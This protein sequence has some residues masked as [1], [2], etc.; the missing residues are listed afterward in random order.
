MA[1]ALG[2]NAQTVVNPSFEDGTTGWN[3]SG[4]KTQTNNSFTIKAGNT[5]MEKWTSRGNTVGDAHVYQQVRNLPLGVYTLTVAAQNIQEDTPNATQSGAWIYAGDSIATVDVR[6][7]YTLRFLCSSGSVEVGFKAVSPTGNWIS[8]DN[9]RLVEVDAVRDELGVFLTMAKSLRC[10]DMYEADRTAYLDILHQAQGIYDAGSETG[11]AEVTRTLLKA[12]EQADAAI[13]QYKR[14]HASAESPLDVT[15]L[16]TNPSFEYGWDGWSGWNIQLQ[17]NTSFTLKHGSTYVEKWTGRGGTIGNSGIQQ[18]IKNMEPGTYI[19]KAAAQNIQEDTPTQK[20]TGAWLVGNQSRTPVYGRAEYEVKFTH[21]DT[22]MKIAFICEDAKGNWVATDNFRLYYIGS[23][24]SVMAQEVADRVANAKALLEQKMNCDSREALEI[25]ISAAESFF[26]TAGEEVTATRPIS[27]LPTVADALTQASDRAKKSVSAY[28]ALEKAIAEA[29]KNYGLGT[30]LKADEYRAAIDTAISVWNDDASQNSALSAQLQALSDAAFLYKINNATGA[31]PKVVTDPRTVHG[32]KE[33]FG[34]MTVS[35]VSS[36]KIKEQGFV[37]SATN[38]EPT[39]LDQRANDYLE[40]NGRIYR[41]SMSPGTLYYI[42]AYCMTN[43]YAVGYGDV[44]RVS[45]LP[46]GHVTWSYDYG[47]DEEAQNN[48][49]ENALKDATGWWSNYTSITGFNIDGHWSPGTPTADCG[50][51]GYMRI[52]TNMGQRCGTVMHEMNHGVGTGTT[53]IWGGDSDS[54]LRVSRNGDWA[55][56]HANGNIQFWEN[57]DNVVICGAY[58]AY[59]WGI[60]HPGQAYEDGG[61]GTALWMNKYAINGAHLEPGAWA[62][63]SNWNDEQILYIGNSIITQGFMEDGM[64]PVNYWSGGV[65]LPTYTFAH[66]DDAKYYLTNEDSKRGRLK[67][68]LVEQAS[69]TLRWVTSDL[70][71]NPDL[72][73][74]GD[75]MNDRAAWYVSFDAQNQVYQFRNAVTGH[76]ISDTGTTMKAISKEKLTKNENFTLMRRRKA[77]A[78]DDPYRG[79]WI[80]NYTTRY[81]LQANASGSIGRASQNLWDTSTTQRW[82]IL[83]TEEAQ[84]MSINTDTKQAALLAEL[85]K[86]LREVEKV[87]YIEYNASADSHT[88]FVEALEAAEALLANSKADVD[89][90]SAMYTAT[91]TA[92]INYLSA[93]AAEDKPFDLTFFMTNPSV[94]TDTKGWS[95]SGTINHNCCEFYVKTFDFNQTL[96]EMPRGRF[97]ATVQGF[98]RPGSYSNAYADFLSGGTTN[99][100]F[101]LGSHSTKLAH[102]GVDAQQKRLGGG[103]A[104]VGSPTVYIPDNMEAADIYFGK[105]LYE[106]SIEHNQISK[107]KDLKL[108]IKCSSVSD[109]YWTIFRNFH[110]YF[111]GRILPTDIEEVEVAENDIPIAYYSL[112]GVRIARPDR[113]AYIIKYKDGRTLKVM[114]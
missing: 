31:V 60:H 106:N 36:S 11:V 73:A 2:V 96:T 91:R 100:N 109:Q 40:H 98:Q 49:I 21:I 38:P 30:G 43:T 104:A 55:G 28:A 56:D 29:E 41:M 78:G 93:V 52:G 3:V 48:R 66:L 50:Y 92:G 77:N 33:V 42:R 46:Q 6:K 54:P 90:L 17:T 88:P 64:V 59:H 99:A 14:D 87:P 25:A 112:S 39:V 16:V 108:G 10:D 57:D 102:I 84:E 103:E 76:Y 15:R 105:G 7:H 20:L 27:E 107:N 1:L 35:G 18:M 8:V 97:V 23:D 45:T 69:G 114:R 58:D 83:T 24:L 32:C 51:G 101:Y 81:S 82:L 9:F 61:G 65:C 111:Y 75:G 62:G 44:I 12:M 13:Y 79:Y 68:Y 34:R 47:S 113:G 37:Y 89:E 74:D 85:V 5:Y 80:T 26:V 71:E 72:D 86:N 53:D 19:L 67:S 4:M 63:P 110:L 94:T 95:E 22:E 70:V